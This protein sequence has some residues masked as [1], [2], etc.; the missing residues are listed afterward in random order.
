MPMTPDQAAAHRFLTELR[1]RISTQPLPYQHG[2]EARAL[3]SMWEV[4][5]HAREA[6][7]ENPGCEVFAART[8]ELLNLAVRPLTARW[9]RAF[10]EGR[11]NGRDG[12]DE[13]RGEL[14]QVQRTLRV[15]ASELHE[16]AYGAPY[17]DARTPDVMADAELNSLFQSLPYGFTA[18]L[19]SMDAMARAIA[20]DEAAAVARRRAKLN[21]K[22]SP[23]RD[24]IGLA[25]S[26]GG[27]RSATFS[28]GVVQVLA[29]K[30]LLEEVDFLSTVSGGGYTGCFMTQQLGAGL[31]S[32]AVASPHG[33]DPAAI[34]YVRQH[35]R[36][37]LLDNPKQ[38]WSMVTATFAGMLLNW[39][40]PV[41]VILLLAL[42]TQTI[43]D[44]LTIGWPHVLLVCAGSGVL[45]L[46]AYGWGMRWRKAKASQVTGRILG[47]LLAIT[48]I[49]G[50]LWG[51]ER[52]VPN[53]IGATHRHWGTVGSLGAA[54]AAV[55][56]AVP[57][58]I[59]FIPVL[60]EPK[61]RKIVLKVA[62]FLAGFL[63][64]LVAILLFYVFRDL[65]KHDYWTMVAVA[66]TLSGVSIFLLNIN[67]TG[68]HRMYRDGLART[69][70]QTSE[71]GTPYV[72]LAE[73]NPQDTAPYHLINA[74]L[75]VP[76]SLDP[77]LKDRGCDFFLFSKGWIGSPAV[78]YHRTNQWK[79]NNAPVDLATAMAISGAAFSSYMGLGSKPTLVALLTIL[80]VR[81]GFWINRPGA[82]G[83]QIPGFT[84]LL[85][86][87]VGMQMSE[88]EEWLNL[89]DG[90]HIENLAIYEL[91]RR[92]CKFVICVDGEADPTFTFQG[93][94]TLVRHAQIDF[95]VRID[96]DLDDIRPDP[97]T[98]YSKCHFHV[99]RIHY[100]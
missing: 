77:A 43:T 22:A 94:M 6:I 14:E 76:T 50:A 70:I 29:E 40:A 15:F 64:P 35:A 12:A 16:M 32:S 33:P 58:I 93:L 4:F 34:R 60:K 47:A 46:L 90:G 49:V 30:G 10:E 78:G 2:V 66:V 75:N 97:K 52:A 39:T 79:A 83:S 9:H 57:G 53:L 17:V 20:S 1:T 8:V 82:S 26:G 100:P 11:L 37:L 88:K 7:K 13:F 19:A 67:L 99:C 31:Q 55:A 18:H 95:G 91:L 23:G 85:R 27:I 81:L 59:R 74:A 73:I 42:L 62:L 28:L 61:I 65:A 25:L 92:R 68:P 84:C 48:A 69:F 44:T 5:G 21:V 51:L 41:S 86:E 3:Q 72:N 89:S 87:M 56:A 80:N 54:L 71:S 38:Q 63:V 98:G 24:A 45:A 96:P 36:Y